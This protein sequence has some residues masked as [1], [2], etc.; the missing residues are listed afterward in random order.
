MSELWNKEQAASYCG[1]PAKFLATQCRHGGGPAFIR[2]SPK[3]LYFKQ[4]DL[5]RWMQ[6]WK[7]VTRNDK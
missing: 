5:D 4:D 2:P 6:T 1:L 3:S 7:Q